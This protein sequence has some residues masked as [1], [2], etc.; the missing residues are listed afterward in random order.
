MK[1]ARALSHI[2]RGAF[3]PGVLGRCRGW[4]FW[5]LAAFEVFGR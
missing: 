1:R 4:S 5:P 2:G 3:V